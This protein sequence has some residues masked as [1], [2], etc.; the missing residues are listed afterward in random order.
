MFVKS[1][2]MP[3]C[4]YKYCNG[5][6]KGQICE[7]ALK[8]YQGGPTLCYEHK[9]KKSVQPAVEVKEKPRKSKQPEPEPEPVK[10][11]KKEVKKPEP[12]PVKISKTK[13]VKEVKKPV[14]KSEPV[15]EVKKSKPVKKPPTPSVSSE[16]ES[17]QETVSESEELDLSESSSEE[18]EVK[19]IPKAKIHQLTCDVPEEPK[20]ET[21]KC[22]WSPWSSTDSSSDSD[23]S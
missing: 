23:S 1:I 9:G 4:N 13:A 2:G 11:T 7:R 5:D 19:S 17:E 18:V 14:K 12:E 15:K 16:S 21:K 22:N 10:K 6:R 8:N 3:K 20:Q